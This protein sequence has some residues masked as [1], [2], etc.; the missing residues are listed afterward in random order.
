MM[1]N[2]YSPYL[3]EHQSHVYID[4]VRGLYRVLE[5]LRKKYPHLP[6]MLCSGGGGRTDYGAMKYFT[7]FWPSDNTDAYDRIFIQWGYSNFFPAN[8][9]CNHVTTMGSQ[10]LKFRTDVA[11]MGKLGYD[12]RVDEM[13]PEELTFSQKAV[14]NYKRLNGIIW[15]GDLYRLIDPYDND[16]AVLMYV[17]EE[18]SSAVLFAYTLFPLRGKIFYPVKL[19]GLDAN[20]HYRVQEINV[21]PNQWPKCQ[22]NGKVFSG[23]YLMKVGIHPSSGDR[24]TSAVIEITE[25]SK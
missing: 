4:Y 21:F 5:D 11:M 22:E 14:E 24:L 23:D 9:I 17:D 3:K 1:T 8:T 18:K 2:T 25:V 13:S 10:S 12:I 16:R 20:K 7:E 19:Q 15:Y 6:I